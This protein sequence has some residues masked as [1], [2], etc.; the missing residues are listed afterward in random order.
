MLNDSKFSGVKITPLKKWEDARGWLCEIWRT[1]EIPAEVTPVM[2]Y[3]SLTRPG[4]VRGP[5][6]HVHQTDLFA[7][8]GPS[9]FC[10]HLW[11][12]RDGSPTFGQHETFEGGEGEPFVAIVPPGVVHGYKNVGEVDGMVVNCA[13]K[14]YKGVGKIEEVDEIRHEA[15]QNSQFKVN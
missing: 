6:E 8:L 11:D 15:D 12:N 2:T 10:L 9:R 14:L 1:D 3:L 7:F 13:N 4:V 5:H